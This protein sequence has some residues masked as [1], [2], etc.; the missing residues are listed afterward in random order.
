MWGTEKY[1]NSLKSLS[2]PVIEKQL[3]IS[4]VHVSDA[5]HE[6]LH[7]LNILRGWRGIWSLGT[8]IHVTGLCCDARV[9]QSQLIKSVTIST[10]SNA[11]MIRMFN[12]GH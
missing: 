6:I 7:L 2:K 9:R 4:R 10:F 1:T 12:E 3:Q 5:L 8:K 11:R